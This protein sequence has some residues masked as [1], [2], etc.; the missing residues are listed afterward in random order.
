KARRSW[1]TPPVGSMDRGEV[2]ALRV[3]RG[4]RRVDGGALL[5]DRR[6]GVA[7]QAFVVAPLGAVAVEPIVLG[8]VRARVR[9]VEL[10]LP[11]VDLLLAQRDQDVGEAHLRVGGAAAIGGGRPLDLVGC[12]RIAAD[13]GRALVARDVTEFFS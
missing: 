4:A 11:E 8:D 9:E 2:A 10:G 6:L 13:G 12:R 1:A 3:E 5:P 7:L